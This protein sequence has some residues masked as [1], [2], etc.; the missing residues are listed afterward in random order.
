LKTVADAKNNFAGFYKDIK[1][2][3]QMM[4]NLIRKYF[5]GSDV[6]A[7]AEPAG[8]NKNLKFIEQILAFD[9]PVYVYALC[10]SAG[11]CQ[12]EFRFEVAIYSRRP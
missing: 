10:P 3:G 8:N 6:V 7:I 9:E 11:K 4:N 12:C 5:A 1:P 2:V